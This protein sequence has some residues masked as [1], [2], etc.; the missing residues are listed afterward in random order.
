MAKQTTTE[1]LY[2]QLWETPKDKFN[3]HAILEKAKKMEKES[4]EDS[5]ADGFSDGQEDDSQDL[6]IPHIVNRMDRFDRSEL[7]DK[8]MDEGFISDLCVIDDDRG[9]LKAPDFAEDL[10]YDNRESDEALKKLIGNTWKLTKEEEDYI[11][12]LAKRF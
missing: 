9:E 12:N 3:W 1:W 5:Y 10:Y 8:L 7:F 4:I 11:I 2:Q 6:D